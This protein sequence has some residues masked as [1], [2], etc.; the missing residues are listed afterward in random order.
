MRKRTAGHWSSRQEAGKTSQVE[1]AALA[2]LRPI[3]EARGKPLPGADKPDPRGRHRDGGG[4]GCGSRPG[5]SQAAAAAPPIDDPDDSD[6][7]DWDEDEVD[8]DDWDEDD[9]DEDEVDDDDDRDDD[10]D[11]DD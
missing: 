9:R 10:D 4:A 8:E 2:A 6:D 3:C 5:V 11:D 7:D 1:E